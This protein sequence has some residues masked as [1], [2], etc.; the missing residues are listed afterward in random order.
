MAA[1][2]T[3]DQSDPPPGAPA[4]RARWIFAHRSNDSFADGKRV[5]ELVLAGRDP[6]ELSSEEMELLA[7][8]YNWWGKHAQAFAVARADLKQNPH[9]LDRFRLAG[10]Y[11]FIAFC[12]DLTG[13]TAACDDLIADGLGL[14]AFWHLLKADQ[15]IAYATGER[16]RPDE[17]PEWEPG[18][19]VP[20]PDLLGPA[21]ALA[22][23]LSMRPDLREDEASR[24][25]VGDWNLR[26]AAVVLQPDYRHL[27]Q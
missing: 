21:E 5:V 4:E 19:P 10:R 1:H 14:A 7:G 26:F 20:R 6:R 23:A 24:G 12:H 8:G 9:S 15:Y 13:F 16:D 17:V 2:R 11:A 18:S 27:A 3:A 25:W 22:A